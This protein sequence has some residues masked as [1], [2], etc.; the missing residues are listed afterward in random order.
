MNGRLSLQAQGKASCV[1]AMQAK[2][3]APGD[4]R[5]F[6]GRYQPPT[7]DFCKTIQLCCRGVRISEHSH[8]RIWIIG[9]HHG[10]IKWSTSKDASTK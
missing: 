6:R 4:S 7:P 3:R 5:H 9:N 2:H 8:V 1:D 10:K